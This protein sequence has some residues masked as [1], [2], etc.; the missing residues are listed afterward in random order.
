MNPQNLAVARGSKEWGAPG[1]GG[2]GGTIESRKTLWLELRQSLFFNLEPT[3]DV[4]T[5]ALTSRTH[6][7]SQEGGHCPCR[8]RFSDSLLN[9]P[10]LHPGDRLARFHNYPPSRHPWSSLRTS[11]DLSPCLTGS[12]LSSLERF[13]FVWLSWFPST[14]NHAIYQLPPSPNAKQHSGCKLRF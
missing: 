13:R 2:G 9:F 14:P 8:A 6:G 7:A 1:K 12:S 4:Q 11:P 5:K 3:V 10:S